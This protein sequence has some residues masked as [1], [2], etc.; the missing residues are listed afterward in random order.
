MTKAIYRMS[1]RK[2][3]KRYDLL[4]RNYP[5]E[6]NKLFIR[7]FENPPRF[8]G[9]STIGRTCV[10][11]LAIADSKLVTLT[12]LVKMWMP[13]QKEQRILWLTEFKSVTHVQNVYEQNRMSSL[14]CL[15]DLAGL[16]QNE[17][18]T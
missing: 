14:A 12:S 9:S 15:I 17:S 18:G 11:Y 10:H 13:Q 4:L 16:L 6:C 1:G 8:F 5:S 2:V 7:G 3:S